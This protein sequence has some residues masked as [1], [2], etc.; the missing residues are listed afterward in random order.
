MKCFG[1]RNKHPRLVLIPR[2]DQLAA[3]IG[4][5]RP[6]NVGIVRNKVA[7]GVLVVAPVDQAGQLQ[8]ETRIARFGFDFQEVILPT[9]FTRPI[10]ID[11]AHAFALT[12]EFANWHNT[13][14]L[15]R[16]ASFGFGR[17]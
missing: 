7:A 15:L 1:P 10:T 2:D 6:V 16:L 9:R 12:T 17:F 3:I 8:N 13:G 14:G 5:I 4:S 11:K